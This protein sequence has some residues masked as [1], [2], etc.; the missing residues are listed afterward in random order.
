[1]EIIQRPPRDAPAPCSVLAQGLFPGQEISQEKH[2]TLPALQVAFVDVC[3]LCRVLSHAQ[4][5]SLYP[6]VH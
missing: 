6:V 1:M 2:T 3:S 5:V 4:N